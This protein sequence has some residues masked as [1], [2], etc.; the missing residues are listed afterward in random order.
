MLICLMDKVCFVS[1]DTRLNTAILCIIVIS[2]SFKEWCSLLSSLKVKQYCILHNVWFSQQCIR[3]VSKTG[4]GVNHSWWEFKNFKAIFWHFKTI[5]PSTKNYWRDCCPLDPPS[6]F[7]WPLIKWNLQLKIN[8]WNLLNFSFD[9][10][11][12]H[13]HPILSQSFPH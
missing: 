12:E 6:L 11:H 8:F 4:G 1:G 10:N 7:W 9:K 3:M 5:K 2:A 13:F